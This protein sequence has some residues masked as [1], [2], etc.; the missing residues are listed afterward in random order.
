MTYALYILPL[1]ILT[2]AQ[3]FACLVSALR[4]LEA[5]NF[6]YPPILLSPQGEFP[7]LKDMDPSFELPAIL[8]PPEIAHVEDETSVAA[9]VMRHRELPIVWIH[10][11]E[12]EVRLGSVYLTVTN[13]TLTA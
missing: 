10:L 5:D 7:H 6:F 9:P 4:E 1:T 3:Q 11:F 13:L 8:V 12:V 2:V